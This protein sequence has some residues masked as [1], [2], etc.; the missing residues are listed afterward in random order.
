MRIAV[1]THGVTL[2]ELEAVMA[3]MFALNRLYLRRNPH[4]PLIYASGV[5][6]RREPRRDDLPGAEQTVRGEER[7]NTI[8]EALAQGWVDCDDAAPWR[9]AELCE[10]WGIQARPRFVAEGPGLW[11]VVVELPNGTREDPCR[12]LGMRPG[13]GEGRYF[14]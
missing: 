4:T 6:Y 7:W 11:H 12:I 1:V 13:V 2:E 5:V 14:A 3:C 8:E 10:R 9:A